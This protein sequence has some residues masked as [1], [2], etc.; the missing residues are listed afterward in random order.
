MYKWLYPCIL[1]C[2]LA[3]GCTSSAPKDPLSRY[4]Y[5]NPE[6]D[7][8]QIGPTVLLE[9]S[10][11]SE[12]SRIAKDATDAL[13]QAMQQSGL[14]GMSQIRPADPEWEALDLGHFEHYTLEQLSAVRKTLNCGA[15]LHGTITRFTPYPHLTVGLR[16]KLIDLNSGLTHWAFEYIWDTADAAT[17]DRLEAFYTQKNVFGMTESQD[18]LGSVSSIKMMKFVAYETSQTLGPIK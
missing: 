5:R 14:L 4:Y 11:K 17:Q 8:T 18:R 2:L 7:V 9:L 12:F 15:V 3:S 13:F 6:L 10:N 1:A 16:L